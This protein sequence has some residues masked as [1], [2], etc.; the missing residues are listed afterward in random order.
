MEDINKFLKEETRSGYHISSKIKKVWKCQLEMLSLFKEVCDRNG[1]RFWLDSGTLLGAVRHRGYI[2]WD[3][4][5]DVIML[6]NDYDRL[7]SIAQDE[8][9]SP[10]VFQTAYTE[11]NF[12]RGHAQIRDVRTTGI[13]PSEINKSFNQGIFIDV[14][15]LDYIPDDE[16][17]YLRQ[18]KR[19]GHFRYRLELAATPL[20]DFRFNLSRLFK[21][22]RYKAMY[23][24]RKKFNELY[25]A[26]EDVFRQ[27][28]A[29]NCT[30]VATSAWKY[31]SFKR[32]SRFYEGSVMMRFEY[33]E[34]PVPSGYDELLTLLYGDYMKPVKAPNQHG[35]VIFDPDTPAEATI[36][37]LRK[38]NRYE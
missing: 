25:S 8:F 18:E 23:P 21:S 26:Y 3:D 33:L 10:Y 32:S 9:K 7:V 17:E 24:T 38:K 16:T 22:I 35:E 1:L 5:I 31:R 13:I 29:E 15:V 27:N 11:D 20:R 4:D 34:M 12:V 36:R 37:Q 6:R 14:F 19:A 30:H 2:P 28:N